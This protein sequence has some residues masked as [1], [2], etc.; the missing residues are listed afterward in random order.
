[1]GEREKEGEEER[2]GERRREGG[3]EKK[4]RRKRITS[5][6]GAIIFLQIGKT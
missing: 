4:R 5:L 1:M 3:R 6:I 2:Q